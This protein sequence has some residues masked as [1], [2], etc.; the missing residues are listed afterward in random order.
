MPVL[1]PAASTDCGHVTTLQQMMSSCSGAL[2][3][4]LLTTPFDVVKVRLQSQQQN[5]ILRSC[6]VMDCR[7]ALDGVCVCTTVPSLEHHPGS[8]RPVHFSSTLDAFVK[9]DPAR[10]QS[11]RGGG[12]L[13]PTTGNGGT[14]DSMATTPHMTN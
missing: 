9:L 6:Y 3:T 8:V 11:R 10:R 5:S 14:N 4:S 12:A 2:M 13:G 1:Q 7:T